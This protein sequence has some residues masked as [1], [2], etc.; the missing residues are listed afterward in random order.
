MEKKD[1]YVAEGLPCMNCHKDIGGDDV[2]IWGGV[3]VCSLCSLMADRMF[4]RAEGELKGLL[5]ML[6]EGI[7]IALVEGRMHFSNTPDQ[8]IP[9]ADLLKAIV[10]LGDMKDAHAAKLLPEK[11]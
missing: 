11:T 2:R 6:R 8:E 4:Q 9:K 5:T 10:E 3:F 7:R 1:S